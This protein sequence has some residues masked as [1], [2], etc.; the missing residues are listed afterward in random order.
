MK[1]TEYQ[2]CCEMGLVAKR[3]LRAEGGDGVGETGGRRFL[4]GQVIG[5]GHDK[6]QET[7][8]FFVAEGR[9]AEGFNLFH[10]LL[11]FGCT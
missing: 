4:G 5:F 8:R 6:F 10:N 3:A 7:K 9:D 11:A 1:E 2:A